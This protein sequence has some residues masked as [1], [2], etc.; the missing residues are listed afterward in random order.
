MKRVIL[1]LLT[2]TCN[3]GLVTTALAQQAIWSNK[4][5]VSPEVHEDRTVTFRIFAPSAE[6]VQ[7]RG[8]FLPVKKVVTPVGT[9]DGPGYADLI[10]N[11][12][13]LWE[14]TSD[15]LRPDLYQ[16]SLL[17]DGIKI[18]DPGNAYTVRDVANVANL[19][20][21][22]G[23]RADLYKVTDVP[24]GTVEHTWYHSNTLNTDRRMSIY[25]PPNYNNGDSYPVLYLLH[26]MGGD[27]EAWLN[28]GRTAQVLDNLIAQGKAKPMIVVMP[29]GNVDMQAGPMESTWNLIQPT[30]EL[31]HTMDGLFEEHF[32]DIV[33]HIDSNYKT[34]TDRASRAIAGLSMG[35][36][37]SR[38]IAA[39][40][41]EMFDY[42][43]LFSAAI[44]EDAECPTM[45]HALYWIGIGE[46]DFLYEHNVRY[47]KILDDQ[48]YNYTYYENE[49][50][51]IWINWRIYLTEFA[52][53][54]F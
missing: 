52:P 7:V 45:S 13:G 1:L 31:P 33:N 39:Q 42:V 4:T 47:R 24:H 25:L 53:L 48:N 19:V 26:G 22:E 6:N 27:E 28:L 20:L 37:H 11:E 44:I 50:G 34:K 36:Y 30:M 43:G 10:R 29:N 17:V 8:D 40:H 18:I 15:V 16:Y 5:L 32:L 49:G 14:W 46:D 21:V 41:P 54:L 9:F 35:G 23:E 12:E 51:H 2:L 38:N 3:L